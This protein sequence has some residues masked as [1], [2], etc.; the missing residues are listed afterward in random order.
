MVG[1]WV[2]VGG[3]RDRREKEKWKTSGQLGELLAGETGGNLQLTRTAPGPRRPP[4]K[5]TGATATYLTL[6]R[7]VPWSSHLFLD[8]GLCTLP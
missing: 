4:A 6:L 8:L 5:E 3:K 7:C 2:V 1:R